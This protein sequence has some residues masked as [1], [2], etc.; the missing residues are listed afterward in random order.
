MYEQFI[1]VEGAPNGSSEGT[2]AFE[3]EIKDAL[4]FTIKL[5]L[6]IHMVVQ[7]LVSK[8]ARNN[9]IKGELQEALYVALEGAPKISL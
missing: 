5:H 9:S 6:K 3:V 8:I 2:P 7:L 4:E 1:A